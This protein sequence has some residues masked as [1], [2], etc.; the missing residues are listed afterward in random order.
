MGAFAEGQK[1]SSIRRLYSRI[2]PIPMNNIDAVWREYCAF[3]QSINKASGEK[4]ASDRLR[5]FTLI[6]KISKELEA[7]LKGIIRTG[8]PVP[9]QE[10]ISEKR[11]LELWQKYINWEKSN[12]LNFDDCFLLAKRVVYAYEQLL[13]HFAFHTSIWIALAQYI[14]RCYRKILSEGNQA[15][16]IELADMCR[17]IYRRGVNGPMHESLIFNLCYVDFEEVFQNFQIC[18]EIY[19]RLLTRPDI[20]KSLVYIH[21]MKHLYRTKGPDEGRS[22]FKRA[23]LDPTIDYRVYV[24]AALREFYCNH[25]PVSSLKVFESGV[26]H[27]PNSPEYLTLYF[28]HLQRLGD[29]NLIRASYERLLSMFSGEITRTIFTELHRFE[30]HFGGLNSCLELEDRIID[31]NHLSDNLKLVLERYALSFERSGTSSSSPVPTQLTPTSGNASVPEKNPL[32][33][34]NQM[35]SFKPVNPKGFTLT[36]P[37]LIPGGVFPPPSRVSE[38]LSRL[39]PPMCFQGP[40]VDVD[41]ILYFFG[42]NLSDAVFEQARIVEEEPTTENARDLPNSETK[43]LDDLYRCRQEKTS[44]RLAT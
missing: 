32:P 7:L 33:D 20:D 43:L 2:L 36:L 14:E 17:D 26:K 1:M 29:S 24:N 21:Y 9:P 41:A 31:K 16:A 13:Q 3:E 6:K 37:S 8:V 27:F 28:E 10:T 44:L 30:S 4:I 18:S 19:E 25:D 42:T 15:R 22:L 40:F 38:L 34:V 35:R 11:Q 5:D 23:R 39:P 12:P